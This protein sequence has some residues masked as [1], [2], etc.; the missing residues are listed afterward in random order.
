MSPRR[1]K[2]EF[3]LVFSKVSQIFQR[4]RVAERRG[5]FAK[6]LKIQVKINPSLYSASKAHAITYTD[7]VRG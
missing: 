6:T 5:Q 1:I 7:R 2:D 3:S 4:F